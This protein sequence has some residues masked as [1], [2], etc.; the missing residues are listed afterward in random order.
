MTANA[1]RSHAEAAKINTESAAKGLAK[2]SSGTDMPMAQAMFD[3]GV[4]HA[5]AAVAISQSLMEISASLAI[6]ARK[7][8]QQ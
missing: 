8:Q 3:L 7:A 1:M 4:A 2:L 6:L 5:Q